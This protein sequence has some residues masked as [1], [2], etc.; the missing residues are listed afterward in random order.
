MA[1]AAPISSGRK[2][3]PLPYLSPT[4]RIASV[5][6]PASSRGAAPVSSAWRTAFSVFAES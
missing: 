2:S 1:S 4:E 6:A 5:M 3:S